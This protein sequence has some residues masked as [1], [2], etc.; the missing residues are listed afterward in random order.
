MEKKSDTFVLIFHIFILLPIH[1]Q[2]DLCVHRFQPYEISKQVKT[3]QRKENFLNYYIFLF[4]NDERK[5]NLMAIIYH[6]SIQYGL[7]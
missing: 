2:V 5:R 6:K 7:K 3:N 1:Q 4:I